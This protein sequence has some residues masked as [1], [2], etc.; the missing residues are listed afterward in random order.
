[1]AI[2]YLNNRTFE[3][4]INRFKLAKEN[5]SDNPI[6]FDG[7]QMELAEAFY[8]LAKNINTGFSIPVGR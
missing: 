6:E 7:A 4:I 5:V 8:L 2:E 1:M 3:I